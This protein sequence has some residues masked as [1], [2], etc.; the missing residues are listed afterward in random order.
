MKKQHFLFILLLGLR[1]AT[2]ECGL[3]EPQ[4]AVP[5]ELTGKLIG[6][7]LPLVDAHFHKREP[8]EFRPFFR[9]FNRNGGGI[10]AYGA[11]SMS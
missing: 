9:R 11:P 2:P 5:D 3:P 7:P 4:G 10:N 8:G 6:N 1:K